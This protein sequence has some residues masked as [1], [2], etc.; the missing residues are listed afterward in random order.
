MSG[1]G[2]LPRC[3]Y[4]VLGESVLTPAGVGVVVEV[5]AKARWNGLYH[6]AQ[7]PA[8]AEVT[9]WWGMDDLRHVPEYGERVTWVFPLSDI[10]R[11]PSSSIDPPPPHEQE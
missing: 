3:E 11:I 4:P 7:N 6:E 5:V 2:N 10:Q 1:Q 9:V 8:N